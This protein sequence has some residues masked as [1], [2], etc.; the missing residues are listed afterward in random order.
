MTKKTLII[1]YKY[2]NDNKV[3]LLTLELIKILAVNRI[4]STDLIYYNSLK[5]KLLNQIL[6]G[7]D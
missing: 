6:Y 4:S 1:K 7:D 5:N 2:D 3:D